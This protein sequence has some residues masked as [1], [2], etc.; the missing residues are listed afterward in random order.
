MECEGAEGP[1]GVIPGSAGLLAAHRGSDGGRRLGK[2]PSGERA[3]PWRLKMGIGKDGV[4]PAVLPSVTFFLNNRA[5]AFGE[6]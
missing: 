6:H 3:R 4:L 2:V 5:L 1:F